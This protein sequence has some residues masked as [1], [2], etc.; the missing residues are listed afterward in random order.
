MSFAPTPVEIG[1][2]AIERPRRRGDSDPVL[3]LKRRKPAAV[4]PADL[5]PI[6]APASTVRGPF[7]PAP[8]AAPAARDA[9]RGGA[10]VPAPNAPAVTAE[11]TPSIV[12]QMRGARNRDEIL[13]LLVT[14]ARSVARRAVVLAVRRDA[15][16]GWTGSGDLAERP[17]LR[18]VRLPNTMPTVLHESLEYD[19]PRFARIRLDAA[20][21]PLFAIMRS[22]PS[23]AEDVVVVSIQA[24]GR[25]V[26]LV[27][28]DG[29]AE[30][31]VAIERV[32]VL[33]RAAGDALARLLRE[34]RT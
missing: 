22:P 3:D 18:A 16:V 27:I 26:A 20:H 32:G 17:A 25:P 24:E 10:A 31:P 29:L 2:P 12:N 5:D 6:Y 23:P 19:G 13:D 21:A 9:G 28:A 33:A 15:L 4:P 1:P 11:E 7:A 8:N 14:G 30:A 34:R